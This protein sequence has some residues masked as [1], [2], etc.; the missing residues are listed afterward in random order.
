[1]GIVELVDA[2]GKFFFGFEITFKKP[3]LVGSELLIEFS[4][5]GPSESFEVLVGDDPIFYSISD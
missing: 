2:H 5:I 4:E 3:F 1:M